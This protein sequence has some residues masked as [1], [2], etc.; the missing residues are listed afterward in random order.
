M[1]GTTADTVLMQP[2]DDF[3]KAKIWTVTTKQGG[4]TMSMMM[5]APMQPS[6]TFEPRIDGMIVSGHSSSYRFAVLRGATD[7][8]RIFE[9]P[10]ATL[11]ISEAMR[12]TLF[13]K[14][15]YNSDEV[16]RKALRESAKKD[17][18]P[19]TW[20]PWTHMSLDRTGRLWVAVPGDSGE[21]TRLQVFDR[22]GLLLGDVPPPN[23]KMFNTSAW[24]RDR[25]AVLD[26]DD[27]G[28]PVIRTFRLQTTTPK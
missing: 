27:D 28:R 9:A 13:E 5:L 20:L 6:T 17:D 26:E 19:H 10:S 7:T 24:G 3:R 22:D 14:A 23:A 11:P 15:I 25:I 2:L 18:I 1:D 16:T 21:I 8:S 12:D 4:N